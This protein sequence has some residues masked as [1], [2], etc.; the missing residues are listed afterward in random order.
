MHC[1]ASS[2]YSDYIKLKKHETVSN[3][4]TVYTCIVYLILLQKL[5]VLIV[6]LINTGITLSL[7]WKA[8]LTGTFS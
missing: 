4:H 5:I 2:T 8:D 7:N 3:V 6:E 1:Q